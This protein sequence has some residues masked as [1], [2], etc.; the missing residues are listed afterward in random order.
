MQ[1]ILTKL[2]G[3]NRWRY[4]K[5]FNALEKKEDLNGFLL[6]D[7]KLF[8]SNVM[9]TLVHNLCADYVWYGRILKVNQIKVPRNKEYLTIDLQ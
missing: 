8:F 3:Y 9:N 6:E 2:Y 4:E 1:R 5:I 7:N